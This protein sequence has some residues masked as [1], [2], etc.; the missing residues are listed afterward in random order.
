MFRGIAIQN[1]PCIPPFSG[2]KRQAKKS[3]PLTGEMSEGQRGSEFESPKMPEWQ[4]ESR[5]K[6]KEEGL[7][8]R[9]ISKGINYEM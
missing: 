4:R 2:G 1:P 9:N 6:D 7:G 5:I 8:I 3:S